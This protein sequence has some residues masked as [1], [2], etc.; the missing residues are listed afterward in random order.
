VIRATVRN[1]RTSSL[2]GRLVRSSLAGRLVRS[3]LAGVHNYLA[4]DLLHVR[5]SLDIVLRVR[6]SLAGAILNRS[7][8]SSPGGAQGGALPRLLD[9]ARREAAELVLLPLL[10]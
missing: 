1:S 10:L 6:I 9:H 2:A 3:S 4:G 5:S 7:T 8:R